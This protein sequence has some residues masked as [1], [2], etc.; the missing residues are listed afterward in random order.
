MQGAYENTWKMD[1]MRI[2]I[3]TNKTKSLMTV[4]YVNY[5]SFTTVVL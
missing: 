3:K 4:D 5:K 2:E 1:R